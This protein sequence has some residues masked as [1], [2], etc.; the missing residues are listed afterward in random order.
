[1]CSTHDMTQSRAQFQR[2]SPNCNPLIPNV[3]ND[4]KRERKKKITHRYSVR[5]L[6]RKIDLFKDF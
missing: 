4:E 1:M 6:V 3:I 5:Q 2:H